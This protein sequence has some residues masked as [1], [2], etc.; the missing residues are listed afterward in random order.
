M[1]RQT[2]TFSGR[3][4]YNLMADYELVSPTGCTNLSQLLNKVYSSNSKYIEIKIMNGCKLL[5][6]EQ[7]NLIKKND[8]FGVESY[9]INGDCLD[10]KLFF[11]TDKDIDVEIYADDLAGNGDMDTYDTNKIAK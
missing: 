4:T 9:F 1:Q 2:K 6:D 3:L 8:K 7:G 11:N 5:F 10:E